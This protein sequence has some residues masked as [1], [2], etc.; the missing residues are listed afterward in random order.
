MSLSIVP[1]SPLSR[2]TALLGAL[3]LGAGAMVPILSA[4]DAFAYSTSVTA[5][6]PVVKQGSSGGAVRVVQGITR[7][8]VDGVFGPAT[9]T[10][11]INFQRSKGLTADGVVGPATWGALVNT[12]R[13]GDN[14]N[15]VRGVQA[16]LSITVDGQF[17][18]GTLSAVTTFQRNNGLT[19]DGVVGPA[20]WAKL[21]G[22]GGSVGGNPKNLYT[23]G[24][25][26]A[27]ALTSVGFGSW[28]LSTYCI[29]D[30]KAMNAAFK[31]RFGKNLPISGSMSAYRTYDQQVYLY[32][33]YLS[34][35]GNLAA[36]PGTSNHGWGLAVDV[37]VSPYGSTM[38]NW[39][40]ANAG[41]W[42]FDDDVSGEPWHWA[43]KR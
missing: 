29:N 22:G 32:N 11:V 2:R 15:I 40:N 21:V 27:S 14:N 36:R 6:Y 20:T 43:Y 18:P 37:S 42:G 33:L 26:P 16:R 28:R 8:G 17:G 24:R 19:A 13:N 3:G 23:N 39:L 34:G 5:N 10:A 35:K 38:Y 1:S 31:T 4:T 41:K 9:K 12:V 7:T 30:F 25:L